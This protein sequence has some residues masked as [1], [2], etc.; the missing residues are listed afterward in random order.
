MKPVERITPSTIQK[1][2]RTASMMDEEASP[3]KVPPTPRKEG[4]SFNF[5]I[6]CQFCGEEIDEE[7]K[8]LRSIVDIFTK[9][10]QSNSRTVY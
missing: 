1:L 7:K 6:R 5:R 10:V 8:K 9:F 3:S 2:K 4:D